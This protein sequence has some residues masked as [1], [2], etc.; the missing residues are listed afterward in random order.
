LPVGRAALTVTAMSQATHGYP[1]VAPPRFVRSSSVP[2]SAGQRVVAALI[3]AATM[4]VLVTAYL[5]EPSPTGLGT[6]RQLGL[7]ACGFMVATG[8]MPCATCGMTTAFSYAAKGQFVASFLTQPAGLMLALCTAAAALVS[9][10]ALVR[11][12]S[13]APLGRRL[14]R[15]AVIWSFAGLI[16]AG[17]GYKILI[18]LYVS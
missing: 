12:M 11:G 13:L 15:P 4:G 5:L 1:A 2:A 17:W 7:P 6:H 3:F 8:G 9:G 18:T 16:A 14:W 10:Y